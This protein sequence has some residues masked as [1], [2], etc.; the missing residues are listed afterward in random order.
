MANTAAKNRG[1]MKGASMKKKR[2]AKAN[3]NVS[4]SDPRHLVSIEC[5]TIAC[6]GGLCYRPDVVSSAHPSRPIGVFDSGLGGLT[7][8]KALTSRFPQEDFLYLGDV[9]RLPYG[10]KSSQVVGR[11]ARRCV[12]YLVE[13]G[14]KAVIIACNT[15]TAA[16][17]SDLQ[18]DSKVPVLGVIEPGADAALATTKNKKILVAA[19]LSTVK[20]EAYLRAFH[21]RGPGG[22]EIYQVPCPLLVPLAEEGWFDNE[23]TDRIIAQYLEPYR[24]TG[25]DTCL[26]G[27]THYPL[28]E[29]AF[30][31]VLGA[32]VSVVHGATVLAEQL[33]KILVERELS[34]PFSQPRRLRFL[35]TDTVSTSN[36]M[37]SELFGTGSTFEIIDL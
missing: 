15:A 21:A 20:S 7:V 1:T 22:C 32:E 24:K 2:M 27:C 3:P 9:A 25:F 17:L 30:R 4:C 23:V 26:L 33:E 36:P 34:N 18:G 12:D 11:Y 8:L 31:R 28:L 37:T 35:S 16:A 5:P 29:S 14:V 6:P 10:T 13:S 19:T